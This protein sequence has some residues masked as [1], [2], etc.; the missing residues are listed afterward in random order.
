M[1]SVVSFHFFPHVDPWSARSGVVTKLGQGTTKFQAPLLAVLEG[2]QIFVRAGMVR[3]IPLS[4][5]R[6]I[7]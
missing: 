3:C 6:F 5:D 7:L 1:F 2:A 4:A